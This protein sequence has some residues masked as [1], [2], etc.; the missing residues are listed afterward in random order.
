MTDTRKQEAR[1]AVTSKEAFKFEE[2]KKAIEAKDK[3]FMVEKV[4]SGP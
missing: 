2:V 3:T 4:V 1:F